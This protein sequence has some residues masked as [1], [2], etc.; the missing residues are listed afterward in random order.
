MPQANNYIDSK[1]NPVSKAKGDQRVVCS[2]TNT[3]NEYQQAFLCRK[4]ILCCS[5]RTQ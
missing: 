2:G 4:Y 5:Y 1:S 3:N